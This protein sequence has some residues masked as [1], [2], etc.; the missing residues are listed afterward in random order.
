MKVYTLD[1][2]QDKHLG[3]IGTPER[4]KFEYNL[5]KALLKIA[6]NNARTKSRFTKNTIEYYEFYQQ[7]KPQPANVSKTAHI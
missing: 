7:I 1:E 2:V 5:K 4:D 6:R 3:K